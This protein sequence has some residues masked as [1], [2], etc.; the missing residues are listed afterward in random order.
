VS[1][2]LT[3]RLS[4]QANSPIGWLVWS[5]SQ[6]EV[7]ASGELGHKGQLSEL[8]AYAKQRTTIA[9]IDSQDLFLA[10]TEVPAGASRQLENMLPY[11]FEEEIAQDVDELHFSVLNKS[12]NQVNV[13]AI[14][15]K[16]L[17]QWLTEFSSIGIEIKKVLP[18]VF[19]LPLIEGR[20]SAIQV[21]NNWLFRKSKNEGIAV[22]SDWL[23]L[24]LQSQWCKADESYIP[25]TSFTAA[26]S[27]KLELQQDWQVEEAE[28]VMALMTREAI[29]SSVTLL[30]GKFKPQS[31]ILKHLKVWRKVAIA[32]CLFLVV[33]TTQRV[34]Q[35]NQ[36]ELE[37][38]AYRTESER[39]FRTVFP[40][41]KK[42][43]TVSYLKRQMNDEVGRLSA[44]TSGESVLNWLSGLP[45]V[46]AEHPSIEVQGIRYDAKR[47]EVRIE[48]SMKDFQAF[49]VV[50]TT[51]S[52]K[53]NVVQGP[54]NK[55]EDRVSGSFTLRKK[56]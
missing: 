49:D 31:S 56:Q 54:L 43:P 45:K 53:F 18:D 2:F 11:L 48:T 44:G 41:K 19:A 51:L 50:R 21:D 17:T 46:L 20:L 35:V 32:A 26:P 37:A 23:S 33:L 10:K 52:E 15:E 6:N 47:G 12:A 38:K 42:I 3:V 30:T 16:Y 25:V 28:L 27:E 5:T 9:I 40:D 8:V 24:F 14:D 34:L 29:N 13:A 4:R 39:V 7:I 36:Y 1:E 22:N 55:K